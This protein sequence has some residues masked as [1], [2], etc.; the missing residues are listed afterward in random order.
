MWNEGLQLAE[1]TARTAGA[2]HWNVLVIN[3]DVSVPPD[4]LVRLEAGLRD[5]PDHWIAYP[6]WHGNDKIPDGIAAITQGDQEGDGR[7]LCGWAF[8]LAGE[9]ELRFDE[10]FS[11]WYGDSDIQR[12][13]E[14]AGKHVV[15]V[16]GCYC[17]HLD[18]MRSTIDDPV[19]LAQAEEDEKKF[20]AKWG[21]DPA[22][23]WLAKNRARL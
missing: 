11:W 15:A 14:A 18:P 5:H 19:R 22:N 12:Q 1:Q 3:N 16:G 10:Q 8:M 21:I 2:T 4:F 23:L 13:T 6:N 7:S 20:A 9:S 17:D